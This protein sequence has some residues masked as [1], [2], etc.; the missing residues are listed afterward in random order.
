MGSESSA[1]IDGVRQ[2]RRSCAYLI[3]LL[4]ILVGIHCVVDDSSDPA[5]RHLSAGAPLRAA[6]RPSQ[7]KKSSQPGFAGSAS[8]SRTHIT[9]LE[10]TNLDDKIREQYRPWNP[11]SA[12]PSDKPYRPLRLQSVERPWSVTN[13]VTCRPVPP[14]VRAPEPPASD[15]DLPSRT[16]RRLRHRPLPMSRSTALLDSSRIPT[17]SLAKSRRLLTWKMRETRPLFPRFQL[18][19]TSAAIS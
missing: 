5:S 2:Q 6:S 19:R 13:L 18:L 16:S 1:A 12:S 8:G 17:P 11:W 10:R 14:V 15:L 7:A 3:I 9:P 4:V